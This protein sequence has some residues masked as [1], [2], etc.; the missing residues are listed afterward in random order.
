MRLLIGVF[1]SGKGGALAVRT[2]K[3]RL[4][5]AD[6][7]FFGDAKNAPYGTKTEEELLPLIEK[8]IDRLRAVGSV[9]ILSACCTAS[10]LFPKLPPSYR[11]TCFP[12][13]QPTVNYALQK[14]K[15]K[16]IGVLATLATVRSH[17]FREAILRA[18]K[19]AFVTEIPAQ[20][21]VSLAEA[22]RTE[23]SDG[24]VFLTC[25][26]AAMAFGR[27]GIDTLIL[28]CTHFPWFSDSLSE[29]FA[30]VTLVSSVEAG[31]S[32]F[33]D[34]LPADEKNGQGRVCYLT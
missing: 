2:L 25:R 12:I 34:T 33:I 27:S 7:A 26:L 30:G 13:I 24:E 10:S 20:K 15:N 1:D 19:D 9:R 6:V 28:G 18:E 29:V 3:R 21:L 31:V 11:D 22:G 23:K 8:D 5:R 14:T 4:P 32:A 16:R 17:V